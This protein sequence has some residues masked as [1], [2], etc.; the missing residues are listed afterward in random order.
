MANLPVLSEYCIPY[1]RVGGSF[2][3]LKGASAA[4]EVEAAKKAITTLGGRLES[5]QLFSLQDS[6]ERGIVNVKKISQTPPKYPRNP[7]KISKQPL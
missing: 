2:V 4:E 7:G 1:V 3:A 5:V 6:G